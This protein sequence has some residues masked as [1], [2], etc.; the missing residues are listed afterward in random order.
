[1]RINCIGCGY[2]MV[3]GDDTCPACGAC[4]FPETIPSDKSLPE[5][6]NEA[7]GHLRNVSVDSKG[8]KFAAFK[9]L[10]SN[11]NLVMNGLCKRYHVTIGVVL[12]YMLIN[13]VNEMLVM[14]I[15]SLQHEMAQGAA[16]PATSAAGFFYFVLFLILFIGAHLILMLG[17][18]VALGIDLLRQKRKKRLVNSHRRELN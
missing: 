3:L 12:V 9:A 5:R 11:F 2:R 16:S 15:G 14:G 8:Q 6:L 1:M 13:T 7:S 4:Q 10:S 18:V 17:G